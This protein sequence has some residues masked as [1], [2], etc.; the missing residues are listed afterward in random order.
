M[1][2]RLLLFP[3]ALT[4][5]A[6]PVVAQEGAAPATP[7]VSAPA[8]KLHPMFVLAAKNLERPWECDLVLDMDSPEGKAQGKGHVRFFY[9]RM[10]HATFEVAVD[11]PAPQ[12][13]KLEML[14]DDENFYVSVA[15][16]DQ[17]AMAFRVS[18]DLFADGPD[19]LAGM[20]DSPVGGPQE[21]LAA[22]AG[23]EMQ[24]KVDGDRT[25][26]SLDLQ[27]LQDSGATDIPEGAVVQMD[28]QTK[29]GFPLAL[30]VDGGEEGSVSLRMEKVSFPEEMDQDSFRW[31]GAPA[32][33]LT[34]QLQMQMDLA[35]GGEEEF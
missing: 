14:C 20:I 30:T 18:L 4:A 2:N 21:I 6:A 22:L 23:L 33:D 1:L 27:Q 13:M 26:L 35:G 17:P 11:G 29:T 28:F 19:A 7:E 9:K 8:A 12:A 31:T 24:E 3:L 25:R 34:A 10:F 5:L 16:E 15:Q 32:I